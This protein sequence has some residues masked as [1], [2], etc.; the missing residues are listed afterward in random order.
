MF[1]AA[2]FKTRPKKTRPE[3]CA[4]C[5]VTARVWE[6]ETHTLFTSPTFLT[7]QIIFKLNKPMSYKFIMGKGSFYFSLSQPVHFLRQNYN[8]QR[9]AFKFFF[10]MF[11]YGFASMMLG[12]DFQPSFPRTIVFNFNS[13][14]CQISKLSKGISLFKKKRKGYCDESFS[15]VTRIKINKNLQFKSNKIRVIWN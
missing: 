1:W 4:F 13:L 6:K 15:L 8:T 3:G 7:P 2:F 5:S 12:E 9:F 14:W 10:H 11:F